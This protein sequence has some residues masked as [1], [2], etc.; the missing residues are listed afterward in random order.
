MRLLQ[1]QR[2]RL[3]AAIF[4]CAI[5]C[6]SE[7][8]VAPG[9][10]AGF[11]TPI[12][13]DSRIPG[14]AVTPVPVGATLP[15]TVRSTSPAEPST[16]Q[17]LGLST[18]VGAAAGSLTGTASL[19]W[20]S[21]DGTAII[22][23]MYGP[24][25]SG[26]GAVVFN[27]PAPWRLATTA[28]I[29]AD[30]SPDFIWETTTDGLRAATF[31]NGPA[32]AGSVAMMFQFSAD[33]KIVGSGDF[34]G[35]T[36]IDLVVTNTV[37]NLHGVLLLNGTSFLS[38]QYLP[39]FGTDWQLNS[40]G[41]LNGDGKPDLVFFNAT[42][43]QF[44]VSLQD[45]LNRIPGTISY[46]YTLSAGWRIGAVAD[47]DYDGKGD[48]VLQNT[49]D[50]QRRIGFM[51]TD[52]TYFIKPTGQFTS[53][54]TVPIAQ[55]VVA[56]ALIPYQPAALN[57]KLTNFYVT[58]SVQNLSKSVPLAAGRAALVRVFVNANDYNTATPIVR[59]RV[60]QSGGSFTDFF[61]TRPGNPPA[62]IYV[63]EGTLT[64]TYNVLIP[65]SHIT[66]G[67]FISIN[68]DP[69]NLITETDES[70]NSLVWPLPVRTL[71]QF[72]VRFVP[73][74]ITTGETGNVS[75][76][77]TAQY[78]K[79]AMKIWPFPSYD[80]DVHVTFNS[81][82]ST[83][84]T[85]AAWS[86]II[87]EV[88]NLRSIEGL[89]RTYYG[90]LPRLNP[91]YGGLG[92]IGSPT[93]IGLEVFSSTD[94]STSEINAHEWGHNFNRYHSPGCGPVDID[95]LYPD[96][97]GHVD[98]YGYNPSG[99]VV[100]PNP[101]GYYDIM[102]YCGPKWISAFTLKA[103]MDF[104]APAPAPAPDMSPTSTLIVWGRI[105]A[106]GTVELEPSFQVNTIPQPPEGHGQYSIEARDGAG[107]LLY[108]ASF[109]GSEIGDG[110]SGERHF[111]FAI[112]LSLEMLARVR[113]LEVVRGAKTLAMNVESSSTALSEDPVESVQNV[114]GGMQLRWNPA[115]YKMVL[116]RDAATGQVI[117]FARGGAARI[118]ARANRAVDLVFSDG[119]RSKSKRV[120]PQ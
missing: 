18:D 81:S 87:L 112:P 102:S 104:M 85:P 100:V 105:R 15:I 68:V 117:S 28:D 10:P 17:F 73:V 92:Y 6:N 11:V 91:A 48:L 55:S 62:P 60:T 16:R 58:Q 90:V 50:G 67:S 75:L 43:S 111:S 71:S 8:A 61:A 101:T 74:H 57:L 52:P 56:A 3:V 14:P 12:A 95:P 120:L 107:S 23:K 54:P 94:S 118:I 38:F 30:G 36:K 39:N 24:T 113:K 66:L 51:D 116:V 108:S 1:T 37:T 41:D 25:F 72:N 26:D 63:T 49:A 31:M 22:W 2:P 4:L 80:A 5:A 42:Q 21:T 82:Q 84:S 32:Y 89:Q 44:L 86:N 77:N 9:H 70:D 27:I 47:F 20:F 114:P 99:D 88:R 106:D 45:G 98:V 46:I 65:G 119:V 79:M 78:M 33:W 13:M 97:T 29:N 69:A 19:I 59:V 83:V 7:R 76:A 35:D 109:D 96:P 34:N 115:A 93:A 103:M 40:V 110:V 53:L 64:N